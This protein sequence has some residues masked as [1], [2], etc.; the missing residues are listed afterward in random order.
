MVARL[1]SRLQGAA[2]SVVKHLDPDQSESESGLQAFLQ[3]LRSSPLQQLPISD[4]FSRLEKW[5]HLRR[6]EKETITELIVREE[7]LFTELQQALVRARRDRSAELPTVRE[8]HP[9]EPDDQPPSTPSRSPTGAF[10]RRT[11]TRVDGESIRVPTTSQHVAGDDFFSD[12]MRGYSL[13]KACRLSGNERQNV[14]VQTSNT[15]HFVQVRRALR[16]L[17]ADDQ[18][19]RR[20]RDRYPGKIWWTDDWSDEWDEAGWHSSEWSPSS[21]YGS[22]YDAYW[23]DWEWSGGEWND[24]DWHWPEQDIEWNEETIEPDEGA[25]G[26]EETSVREACNIANEAGRTL[27]EAREAVRKVRQARGYYSPEGSTGKGMTKSSGSGSKGPKGKGKSKSK[28]SFGPCFICGK[29]DHGYR[30]CPDRHSAHGGKG[31]PSKGKFLRGK[32]KGSSKGVFH[33][34]MTPTMRKFRWIS[35]L[36]NGINMH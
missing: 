9:E 31:K 12:E 22:D 34:N 4:S 2:K 1:W 32:G 20:P 19:H 29:A 36:H 35:F 3:V 27:K 11:A 17:F 30:Q 13:L 16:T 6:G 23:A 33:F 10:R 24:D 5:N 7:V 18:T 14:L 8:E 28:M 21:A 26:P 15:T 25:D